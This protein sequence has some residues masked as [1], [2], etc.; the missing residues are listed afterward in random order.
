MGAVLSHPH[1]RTESS[2]SAG[3]KEPGPPPPQVLTLGVKGLSQCSSLLWPGGSGVAGHLGDS[4]TRV[5]KAG[6]GLTAS[7]SCTVGRSGPPARGVLGGAD[8]ASGPCAPARSGVWLPAPQPSG[9]A[10]CG[11]FS[12]PSSQEKF[13][14][15]FSS[16]LMLVSSISARG[17]H[18]VGKEAWRSAHSEAPKPRGE[19]VGPQDPQP[20]PAS[21]SAHAAWRHAFRFP[22]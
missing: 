5:L 7:F 18:S 19:K 13:N 17:R 10:S 15:C 3:R 20:L 22:S 14:F 4:D 2:L 6:S 16:L 21:P 9:A 1:K 12:L 8:P 11:S